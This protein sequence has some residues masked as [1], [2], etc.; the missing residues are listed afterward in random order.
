MT[1]YTAQETPITGRKVLLT[2]VAFFGVIIAVNATMLTLAVKTFGGLVVENSYVASQRFNEDVAAARSQ[3]IRQWS[4]DV[5]GTEPLQ[6]RLQDA[7]SRPVQDAHF[8]LRAVR[9]T[10]G[11]ETVA[12]AFQ[13][14]APGLYQADNT[15]SPGQWMARIEMA[16][17]DVRSVKLFIKRSAG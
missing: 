10:R 6:L 17:G 3:P 13:E 2:I 14:V 12:L 5:A 11:D 15:L 16:S 4:I 8:M 9:P 1:D 7:E